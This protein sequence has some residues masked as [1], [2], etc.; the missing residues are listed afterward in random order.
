[1]SA[2]NSAEGIGAGPL[3]HAVSQFAA[4]VRD[5]LVRADRRLANDEIVAEL[6][7]RYGL[8][9]TTRLHVAVDSLLRAR[10][11]MFQTGGSLW[12]A[13]GQC[14]HGIAPVRESRLPLPAVPLRAEQLDAW[15]L[16]P[17]RRP[18]AAISEAAR[19]RR[20]PTGHEYT[21]S[22]LVRHIRLQLADDRV[23]RVDIDAPDMSDSRVSLE[24]VLDEQPLWMIASKVRVSNRHLFTL[25]RQAWDAWAEFGCV[26]IAAPSCMADPLYLA[27]PENGTVAAFRSAS[28]R[29]ALTVPMADWI[30]LLGADSPA[31][32]RIVSVEAPAEELAERRAL[33]SEM[34]HLFAR[35]RFV[36]DSR[37]PASRSSSRA[38]RGPVLG[39]C[40]ACSRE[41]TTRESARRGYG[42]DC[43]DNL[44]GD[45]RLRLVNRSNLS[46]ERFLERLAGP[47]SPRPAVWMRAT[48]Q[49]DWAASFR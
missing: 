9:S 6:A 4:Q 25:R 5:V 45:R 10:P 1:V 48:R 32:L 21:W 3:P 11:G 43:W 35:Q 7:V 18:H 8:R 37:R 14:L 46:D 30:P 12:R 23:V 38:T 34:N 17:E 44:L 2:N 26:G 39:W 31:Q 40:L 22:E 20:L 16:E 27:D 42:P 28:L 29:D 33:L 47:A 24:L 41:L 15:A 36:G 19:H 49:T 13:R